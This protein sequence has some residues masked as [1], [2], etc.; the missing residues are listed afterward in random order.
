MSLFLPLL[1]ATIFIAL[2]WHDWRTQRIPHAVTLPAG[3][4]ALAGAAWLPAGTLLNGLLGGVVCGGIIAALRHLAV[5]RWGAGAVGFGDVM[6]AWLMGSVGG[7]VWGLWMVAVGM[8]ANGLVAAWWKIG[9]LSP[10]RT[11]LPL[12]VA[13]GLVAAALTLLAGR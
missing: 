4:V 1:Y 12:G 7:V 3:V 2:A 11:R 10:P 8:L 6:L 5:R 9:R 13:W